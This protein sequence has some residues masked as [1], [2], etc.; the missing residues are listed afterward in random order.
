MI[1]HGERSA[2]RQV[3]AAGKKYGYGNMIAHLQTAWAKMLMD[4]YG[5]SEKAAREATARSG[6]NGYSFEWQREFLEGGE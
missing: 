2:V 6:D 5:M 4:E 1:F 3:L